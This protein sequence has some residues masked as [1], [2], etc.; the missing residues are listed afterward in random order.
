[1]RRTAWIGTLACALV[2]AGALAYLYDPPWI[3]DV[4][5]GLSAW[6]TDTQGARFRW[7][8]G[9]GSFFIPSDAT[10]VTLPLRPGPPSDNPPITIDVRVDDRWLATLELPDAK[11]RDPNTWVRPTL[12]LPHGQT[13]RRYRRVDVRVSRWQEFSRGVQLGV[14]ELQRPATPR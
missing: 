7:T 1:M 2:V 5:S 12:P 6:E 9:R 14:V 8:T 13:K 11:H 3:G 10:A 4:T